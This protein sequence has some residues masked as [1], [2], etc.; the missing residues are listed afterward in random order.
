VG[1]PVTD[2]RIPITLAC[3]DYDRT[4]ALRTGEIRPEGVDLTYL[5]MPPEEV[6]YRSLRYREFEAAEMS[7]SSY[8]M[9]FSRDG[10]FVAIPVFPSR[11]FRQARVHAIRGIG[12]TN[13]LRYSLPWLYDDFERTRLA[14]GDDY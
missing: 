13:A 9:N 2:G 1:P 14:M 8:V 3:G 6:F 4:E 5:T 10:G 11:A 7:L 12:E